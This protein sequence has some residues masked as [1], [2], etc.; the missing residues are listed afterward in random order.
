[1][2]LRLHVTASDCK[3][4]NPERDKESRVYFALVSTS[5]DININTNLF[6]DDPL[7]TH[8]PQI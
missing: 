5:D 2:T 8:A 4:S 1:M 3:T 7:P 6:R